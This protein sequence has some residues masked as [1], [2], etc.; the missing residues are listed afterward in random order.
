MYKRLLVVVACVAMSAVSAGAA[1][2][3]SVTGVFDSEDSFELTGTI[4]EVEW[5]NPHVYINLAV[6]DDTGGT[7]MWHL[8]TLPTQFFRNGGV[9]KAMLEGDGG[10]VTITGIRAHDKTKFVGWI[11]RITY[12]DGRFI[13]M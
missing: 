4:M 5:I 7:T 2:H 10:T 8:E 13:Q 11:E 6:P 3:H 12:A 1:A 9:S